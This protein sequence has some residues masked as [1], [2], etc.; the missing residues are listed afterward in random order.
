MSNFE[1]VYDL[2]FQVLPDGGIELEQ[3]FTEVNSISLHA[4]HVRLLLE[5]AG[6][7][8]P[9]PP[10]DDLAKRLAV[11]LCELRDGLLLELGRSPGID[12][13]H[14]QATAATDMLPDSVYPNWL[15]SKEEPGQPP[16]ESNSTP[17]RVARPEFQ[18]THPIMEETP[19]STRPTQ[20]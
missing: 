14:L 12:A 7:L 10:A 5:R 6:H 9:A 8:L 2:A 1:R 16:T 11:Q 3:G 13:L 17:S 15:Y 19:C 18:L 20:P 4:C